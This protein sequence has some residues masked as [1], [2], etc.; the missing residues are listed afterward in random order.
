MC[1]YNQEY[2]LQWPGVYC[3][4]LL[5]PVQLMTWFNAQDL[6][7]LLFLLWWLSQCFFLGL[8]IGIISCIILLDFLHW[9]YYWDHCKPTCNCKKHYRENP[10]TYCPPQCINNIVQSYSNIISP[11]RY[12]NWSNPPIIFRFLQICLHS[13]AFLC[14]SVL[15]CIISSI[16]FCSLRGCIY[17]LTVKIP[18]RPNT[19]LTPCVA[20]LLPH[21]SL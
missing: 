5:L 9:N 14:E 8:N 20:L 2:P 12:W 19:T 18:N 21:L 7:S 1:L 4:F 6:V 13:F 17:I 10:C 3:A 16:Q 15:V 11:Q